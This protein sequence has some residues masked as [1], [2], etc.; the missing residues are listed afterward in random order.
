M[1]LYLGE[2]QIAEEMNWRGSIHF[3]EPGHTLM[4]SDGAGGRIGLLTQGIAK[5]C[6]VHE[7]GK[8]R[9]VSFLKPLSIFGEV[10]ALTKEKF[11]SNIEIKS[12]TPVKIV[13]ATIKDI[14]H[15]LQSDPKLAIF[16]LRASC[17][18]VSSLVSHLNG[19]SFQDTVT[20]VSSVLLALGEYHNQ[21]IPLTHE[22][23]AEIVGK[24]RVTIS[25]ALMELQAAGVIQQKKKRIIILDSE[26]LKQYSL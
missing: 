10:T 22:A 6:L 9:L 4:D 18:K 17:E 26:K 16:L 5:M 2:D 14:E 19:S 1:R 21:N 15:N 3:F 20:M 23:I 8:E 24:N 13:F 25:R 11:M 7:D 12:V